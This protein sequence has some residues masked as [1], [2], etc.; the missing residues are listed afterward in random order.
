MPELPEGKTIR[1]NDTELNVSC[2]ENPLDLMKGLKGV[3]SLEPYDGML[4]DFG[5]NMEIIM[6]P[7]GCLFPLE[8]AF[9]SDDGEITEIKT[10][11]PANGFTQGSSNKVRFALEV[12]F[13]FFEKNN[14]R[15]GD[16][17]SNL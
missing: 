4:F 3:A 1:I 7:K 8:V 11:D 6:T 16:T 5:L 17:I 14:I 2:A 10:L 13:G 15:V 12:P 9:I